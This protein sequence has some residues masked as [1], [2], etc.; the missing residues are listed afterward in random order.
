MVLPKAANTNRNTAIFWLMIHGVV[1][2]AFLSSHYYHYY[3]NIVSSFVVAFFFFNDQ[4]T[5]TLGLCSFPLSTTTQFALLLLL[6]SGALLV[7]RTMSD[8]IKKSTKIIMLM[9]AQQLMKK[10]EE[11]E[12]SSFVE[13]S[14]TVTVPEARSVL[15]KEDKTSNTSAAD[16]PNGSNNSNNNNNNNNNNNIHKRCLPQHGEPLLLRASYSEDFLRRTTPAHPYQSTQTKQQENK[17]ALL[18]GTAKNKS[19][20]SKCLQLLSNFNPDMTEFRC[21]ILTKKERTEFLHVLPA[22]IKHLQTLHLDITDWTLEDAQTFCA[23]LK[24]HPSSQL[25]EVMFHQKHSI[26]CP[27]SAELYG[28]F[29]F[30]SNVVPLPVLDCF[31]EGMAHIQTNNILKTLILDCPGVPISILSKVVRHVETLEIRSMQIS[32]DP[33]DAKEFALSLKHNDTLKSLRLTKLDNSSLVYILNA[34]TQH[35]KEDDDLHLE[36]LQ[37]ES[38]QIDGMQA[39]GEFIKQCGRNLNTLV[40]GQSSLSQRHLV[41]LIQGLLSKNNQVQNLE[42]HHCSFQ[43]DTTTLLKDLLQDHPKLQSFSVHH[44]QHSLHNR[45]NEALGKALSQFKSSSLSTLELV[46]SIPEPQR[47]QLFF[48]WE[49]VFPAMVKNNPQLESLNLS[50]NYQGMSNRHFLPMIHALGDNCATNLKRLNVSNGSLNHMSVACLM[51]KTNISSQLEYL[52]LSRNAIGDEGALVLAK[53]LSNDYACNM[54]ELRLDWCKLQSNGVRAILDGLVHNND[55]GNI[56][57]KVLSMM[58]CNPL[59]KEGLV[60]LAHILPTLTPT[61]KELSISCL[62]AILQP[63]N[64]EMEAPLRCLESIQTT[65]CQKAI[66]EAL[67]NN[68]SLT[69]FHVQLSSPRLPKNITYFGRRNELY[70]LLR[71]NENDPRLD[72]ERLVTSMHKYLQKPLMDSATISTPLTARTGTAKSSTRSSSKGIRNH[73]AENFDTSLWFD[74]LTRRPDLVSLLT[75]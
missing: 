60:L 8:A 46:H 41:P 37:A 39:L 9:K 12:E 54:R 6:L 49:S 68:T 1:V 26:L 33:Q 43:P 36:R 10:E 34:M 48:A 66:I 59:G 2:V 25:E 57:L 72:L 58:W 42:F 19:S 50:D 29:S 14:V 20:S 21:E 71:K 24:D 55:R 11:E 17:L 32:H 56:R 5:P 7:L 16:Q 62:P 47:H 23:V 3:N 75:Q 44:M 27:F 51:E 63:R 35:L 74:C 18:R 13:D 40:L 73:K 22:L 45:S 4:P 61:L 38:F 30:N 28:P 70:N 52:N 64:M 67:Q 69:H 15:D 31:L 53:L 65:A